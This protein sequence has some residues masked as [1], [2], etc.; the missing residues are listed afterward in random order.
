MYA[1]E[2]SAKLSQ[3]DIADIW[4]N[5]PP[6]IADKFEQKDVVVEE[7]ELLDALMNSTENIQWM[8]FKVKKRAES[9]YQQYRRSLVSEDIGALQPVVGDY[10]YNWPYD[11][12]SLVE[13]AKI[14]ETVRYASDDLTEAVTPP[15][16]RGA[17]RRGQARTLPAPS[18]IPRV[19]RRDY[20]PPQVGT[21]AIAVADAAGPVATPS[22]T[23]RRGKVA[24]PAKKSTKRRSTKIGK[25]KK[26]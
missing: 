15:S 17:T 4:Q 7:T 18:R 10:S 20:A 21:Q 3:K 16:D 6:E 25:A 5:L 1:F 24:K 26:R 8:V 14:D 13:L 2:F 19:M 11:F 22:P 12:F 23:K 9:N